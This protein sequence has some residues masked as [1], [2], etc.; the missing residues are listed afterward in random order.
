[1]TESN[2]QQSI[3][4]A[5]VNYI[6]YLYIFVFFH[7]CWIYAVT[8]LNIRYYISIVRQQEKA[9]FNLSSIE[10]LTRL[11]NEIPFLITSLLVRSQYFWS[12]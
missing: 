7:L 1:M 8:P 10:K 2:Q 5:V 4:T 3:T 11:F 9:Y 12:L 6:L